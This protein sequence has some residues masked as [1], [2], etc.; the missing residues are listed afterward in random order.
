MQVESKEIQLLLHSV[1]ELLLSIPW[2]FGDLLRFRS[3]SSIS[4]SIKF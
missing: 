4:G 2:F 3:H 1:T